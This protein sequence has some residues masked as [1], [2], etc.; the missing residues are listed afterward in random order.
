MPVFEVPTSSRAAVITE[1]GTDLEVRELP[2]PELEPGAILVKIEAGTV[3]GSDVH[4]WDGSLH[5][6]GIRPIILPVVPGHEMAGV[7]VAMN[8]D[9]IGFSGGGAV[10]LGDRIVFTQGRCGT[11]YHCTVAEQPNLCPNRKNYGTNCEDFPYLVGGFAEYCYV[12]PTS[13]KVKVPD[14]VSPEWASAG[15]CALRT[16]IHAY[17]RLGRIEPWQTVVIQGAGPLGLFAT[18]LA[19]RSGAERIIVVGAPESRLQLAKDWGATDVVSV[20]DLPEPEA[21]VQAIREL[22][23]GQGAEIVMEWSGA[24]SAFGEGIDM[25]RRGGRFL[26]GGQVGPHQSEFQPSKIM[27]N[28]LSV[29]GSMSASD[30]HYWKAMQFLSKRQDEFDFDRILSNR[31]GLGGVSDA[32]RGM[33]NLTEIKP[34]IDPTI[35]A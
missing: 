10:A 28:E 7:V 17:E 13:R 21:R 35:W 9:D 33:Q 3:C 4:V 8:G 1:F 30:S 2:V 12:Y 18:A 19:K 25:V 11:C 32:I 31:F 20:I 34:V 6:G 5:A 24:R 29:I 26:V 27:K 16:I 15:S 14:D 22:T 23:G